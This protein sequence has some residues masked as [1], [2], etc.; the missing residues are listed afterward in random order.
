[1][2]IFNFLDCQRFFS[3]ILEF[4]TFD[5]DKYS[6]CEYHHA[7]DG[8]CNF[9]CLRFEGVFFHT[10][11]F[12][13]WFCNENSVRDEDTVSFCHCNIT[14]PVVIDFLSTVFFVNNY[15]VIYSYTVILCHC[16]KLIV[17]L[18]FCF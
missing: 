5:E 14:C 10:C 15:T 18:F 7:N 17:D 6:I 16:L 11:F 3:W 13:G 2:L 4:S 8:E 9:F 12:S 1:M